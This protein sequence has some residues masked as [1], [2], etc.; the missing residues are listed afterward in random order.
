MTEEEMIALAKKQ[1]LSQVAE[2]DVKDNYLLLDALDIV[3]EN[4]AAG[5][6]SPT[7]PTFV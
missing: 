7:Y 4:S 5:I 1:G 3:L 6:S 2:K